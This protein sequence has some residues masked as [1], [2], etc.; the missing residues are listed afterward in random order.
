MKNREKALFITNTG[1]KVGQGHTDIC[2]SQALLSLEKTPER[3]KTLV[4]HI[5][6]A[7]LREDKRAS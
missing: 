2:T 4:T 3:I 7:L 5:K 1:L 6:P